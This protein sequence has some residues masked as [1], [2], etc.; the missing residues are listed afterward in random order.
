TNKPSGVG[1]RVSH[2]CI[3]MYPEDIAALFERVARGTKVFIVDQPV[4]AGW[5]D[6]ELY[7]EVHQPLEEDARDLAAEVER[8]LARAL[9]RGGPAAA[10]I[11]LDRALIARITEE[12]R[13][14][15]FPVR[16]SGRTPEQYLVAAARVVENIAPVEEREQTA[17]TAVEN[18]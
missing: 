12:Q 3:R 5:R 4:L 1:M 10:G 7:L 11:E 13:G 15:P 9:E 6:G 2:G 17:S 8:V 14:I 16:K 18:L